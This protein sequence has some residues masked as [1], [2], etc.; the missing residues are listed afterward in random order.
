MNPSSATQLTSQPRSA[1]A[2]HRLVEDCVGEGEDGGV[3]A[4]D[5]RDEQHGGRA[6]SRRLRKNAG[7]EPQVL[8]EL[9]DRRR[10]PHR[11]G[12]FLRERDAAERSP[13]GARGLVGGQPSI[14]AEPGLL[15]EVKA[16]FLVHLAVAAMWEQPPPDQ[17]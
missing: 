12:R 9:F 5:E 11:A 17:R 3:A 8:R 2:G 4:N 6:H 16:D 15:G 13:R 14:D 7:S 1:D 10:D